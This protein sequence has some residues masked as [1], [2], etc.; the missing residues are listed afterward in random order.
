MR[1]SVTNDNRMCIMEFPV[2]FNQKCKISISHI[3]TAVKLVTTV[4]HIRIY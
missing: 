4:E 3:P 1:N 2:G